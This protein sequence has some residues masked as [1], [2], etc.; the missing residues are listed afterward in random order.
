MDGI[1]SFIEGTRYQKSKKPLADY[2]HDVLKTSSNKK[3]KQKVT[4]GDFKGY[5][6]KTLTLEERA[7]CWSGCSHWITCYGNNMPFAHRLEHGPEL[8][9]RIAAEL[10]QHF[11]KSYVTGLLVR[12]HVLGDFYS[13]G[14][15]RLWDALLQLYP[16]LAIWGYTH[17]HPDCDDPAIAAIGQAIAETQ[18]KHGKRFAVRWSDRPEL[19]YSANSAE[20]DTP[21]KGRSIICPEQ[22]G[23]AGGCA[24]CALCWEQPNRNVIFLTH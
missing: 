10:G 7:T 21:E 19:D 5:K 20:L 24:N 15:V 13:V 3:L 9:K 12:L 16:K 23:G 11:S 4:K 2:R 14:Y 22:T 1:N 18:A 17:N 8:E 6:I